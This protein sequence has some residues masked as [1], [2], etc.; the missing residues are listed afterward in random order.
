MP[1]PVRPWPYAALCIA[2]WLHIAP[3]LSVY[4]IFRHPMD[5][6]LKPPLAKWIVDVDGVPKTPASSAWSDAYTL[7]LTVAAIAVLPSVVK[8]EYDG[9]HVDLQTTWYKQWEPW[10]PIVADSFQI[11][12]INTIVIWYGLIVNIPSGWV[13]CDGNNGTPDLHALFVVGT[14]IIGEEKALAGSATHVHDFTTDGH[15]HALLTAPSPHLA[16]GPDHRSI[17]DIKVDT[18]TTD[19]QYHYPPCMRLA[20]IMKV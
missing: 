15:W 18:G 1:S 13:L 3:T 2:Q 8:V 4:V 17:T 7:V 9:P 6:N 16:H 11:I 12:P 19:S 20:Y 5:Q 10:G 14:T